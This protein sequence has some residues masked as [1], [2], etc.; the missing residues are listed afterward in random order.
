ML[1]KTVD[2]VLGLQNGDEGKGRIVDELSERYDLIV[3]CTSGANAGHTIYYD[4]KKVILR[5]IPSGIFSKNTICVLAQGMV[6]N[7]EIFLNEIKNIQHIT[8]DIN[9]LKDRLLISSNAHLITDLHMTED[10]TSSLSNKIGTTKNGIGQAYKDKVARSGIRLGDL[11]NREDFIIKYI[12]SGGSSELVYKY[13]DMFDNI[14]EYICDTS[15]I[16][17]DA[18]EARKNILLEGAQGTLLD[19]DHGTYPF[20]TSSNPI[21]SGMCVGAGIGPTHVN[22][23]IGVC[24]AY[25]TK[26][27][28]GPF[29]TKLHEIHGLVLENI[30]DMFMNENNILKQIRNKGNEFGS[31]TKRP[32]DVGWLDLVLLKYACRINSVS[33]LIMTKLDVL[34]EIDKINVCTDYIICSDEGDYLGESNS[35]AD[36]IRLISANKVVPIYRSFDGWGDLSECKSKGQLPESVINFIDFISSYLCVQITSISIGPQRKDTIQY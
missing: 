34:S 21:A 8:G 30:N 3:R 11:Y 16:I 19:L 2:I 9:F 10:S 32:R 23:V 13:L 1:S 35:P 24:K 5:L 20:V 18:I 6:I 15:K 29:P 4:S 27:G 31:V 22:R 14:K 25:V 28:A 17:N 33:E 7:L 12:S 26:V 36:L